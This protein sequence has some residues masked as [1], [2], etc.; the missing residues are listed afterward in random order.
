MMG[1]VQD[2]PVI[3]GACFK[4]GVVQAVDAARARVRV[5]FADLDGMVSDW[6][7]VLAKSSRLTHEVWPLDP[8]DH[9]ACLMDERAEAGVVLGAIY[10]DAEPPPVASADK[11]HAAFS[12]GTTVEYDRASHTLAVNC[13][14]PVNLIAAGPVTV[15]APAVTV[16]SPLVTIDAAQTTITGHLTVQ[17]G[18]DVAGGSGVASAVTGNLSVNGNISAT[19]SIV[20][21]GGNTNHHSHL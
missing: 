15:Q 12:D 5:Q 2:E 1:H 8:G 9:V 14:G 13:A 20:D 11:Y 19:G 17:N 6:L 10:S 4:F 18:I 21:A 16:Q 7:P 3:G